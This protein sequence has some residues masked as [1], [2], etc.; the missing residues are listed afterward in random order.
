MRIKL[1]RPDLE[2]D[3][4]FQIVNQKEIYLTSADYND[5]STCLEQLQTALLDLRDNEQIAIQVGNNQQYYFEIAELAQSPSFEEIEAASEVLSQLKE[6]A[7]S[8]H[9]FS[10][11]YKKPSKKVVSK[12]KIGVRAEG[13]DF[14]KV[15]VSKQPGFEL[16]DGKDSK[17]KYF[18]FNDANGKAILYSRVFD[19]KTRRL[20]AINAIITQTTDS[21]H[22]EVVKQD[23]QFFFIFKTAEGYEIARSK[24][25]KSRGKM[26]AAMAYLT[27]EASNYTAAFKIPK[28]KKKKRKANEKYHLKQAS[29]QGLIG[30]EGFKSAKN[31]LHYFHYNDKKGNALLFSKPFNKRCNRDE[32]IA[33]VLKIGTNKKR[34]KTWK[35]SKNQFYFSII[36]TKGKSFARS[37]YFSSEKKML[38]ALNTFKKQVANYKTAVNEVTVAKKK[39]YTIS[40]PEKSIPVVAKGLIVAAE[41]EVVTPVISEVTPIEKPD[42][43]PDILPQPTIKIEREIV[44]EEEEEEEIVE[45]TAV[46]EEIGATEEIVTNYTPP[47]TTIIEEEEEEETE[48]Q[49]APIIS[50]IAKDNQPI[51]QRIIEEKPSKGFPWLWAILGTLTL[52]G[53]LFGL[54]QCNTTVPKVE[55]KPIP[56]VVETPRPKPVEPA[57]LGPTAFDLNLTPNT[58]E[59]KIADFLST[60]K[61]AVPRTF[62]L[63]S[64]QFPFNSAALTATSHIQLDNVVRVMQEYPKTKIEVNGHTDSRGDDARNLVLSQNRANAVQAY[65]IAKGI[66]ATRIL[67]AVG[68]GETSPISDNDTE[69]GMQENRRSEVVVMER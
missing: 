7:H 44:E 30:F 4:I 25:F 42:V 47:V 67:K 69:E 60:S 29:P 46:E 13:Y 63:E 14:D 50:T 11:S 66:S 3:Y 2:N 23:S 39:K 6:F 9:N 64:V 15:S 20:K 22:V 68:F 31:K 52:V 33:E 48:V 32:H 5:K 1:L 45:P 53:L 59:A 8:S 24:R 16:I 51:Q 56:K 49:P 58:A 36:D 37:R 55:P 28:K 35:K 54:K 34:F 10:V 27:A 41:E 40:L 62:V 17:D 38:A 21:K 57:K 43:L 12:Q 19:G 61:L 26:E 65:L 18:H